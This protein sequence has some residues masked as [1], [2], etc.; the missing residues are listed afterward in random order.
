MCH[1]TF[2][3]RQLHF[4]A[5]QL[6]SP[7]VFRA[8]NGLTDRAKL[9]GGQQTGRGEEC[10]LSYLNYK[11]WLDWPQMRGIAVILNPARA[12]APLKAWVAQ[13][14][15]TL[16]LIAQQ[17]GKLGMST[18]GSRESSDNYNL[19]IRHRFCHRERIGLRVSSGLRVQCR[20]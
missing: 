1:L 14:P 4:T 5:S 10:S 6:G 20:P 16:S 17:R 9:H 8:P 2:L 15:T 18:S 11:R 13:S 7:E 12:L 3:N 19:P